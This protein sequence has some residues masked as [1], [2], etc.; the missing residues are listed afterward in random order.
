M[1]QSQGFLE[2]MQER[3]QRSISGLLDESGISTT[4]FYSG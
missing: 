1:N 3:L 4:P 2:P